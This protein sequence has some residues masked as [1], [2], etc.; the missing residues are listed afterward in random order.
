MGADHPAVM[1]TLESLAHACSLCDQEEQALRYYNEC[2]ER[3]YEQDG[4][5]REHQASIMVK[6]SRIH[7]NLGDA[8]AHMEKLHLASK[9]LRATERLS[10]EGS[11]L[12]DQIKTETAEA[13][14]FYN[15]RGVDEM[16][17]RG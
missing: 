12:F 10:P 9:I 13:R 17:H 1:G 2:L 5:T 16:G 15:R 14:H 8:E 3:L 7:H 6:M 4:D 11:D